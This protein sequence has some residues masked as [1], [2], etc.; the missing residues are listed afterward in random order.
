MPALEFGPAIVSDPTTTASTMK[1]K[2]PPASPAS[3]LNAALAFAKRIPTP[4]AVLLGVIIGLGIG[5][6]FKSEVSVRPP[7]YACTYLTTAY[8]RRS[9]QNGVHT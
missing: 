8:G 5:Q 3:S 7:V 9:F 6:I 2:L 1:E 4:L